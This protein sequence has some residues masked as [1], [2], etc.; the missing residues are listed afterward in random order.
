M[1]EWADW[2]YEQEC[3]GLEILSDIVEVL[4]DVIFSK[5]NVKSDDI[6]S[7]KSVIARKGIAYT[8]LEESH[9]DLTYEYGQLQQ[10][11]TD[12]V[13]LLKLK[14]NLKKVLFGST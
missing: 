10:N 9:R 11:N 12:T 14:Q 7:V 4:E 3:A 8:N 6:D 1:G 2:H 13:D 5:Y